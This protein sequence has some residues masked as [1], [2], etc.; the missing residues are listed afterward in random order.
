MGLCNSGGMLIPETITITREVFKTATLDVKNA[1]D[2]SL[3]TFVNLPFRKP[4]E[5]LLVKTVRRMKIV[6]GKLFDS[7][8]VPAE[9]NTKNSKQI[10][11][12]IE[13]IQAALLAPSI[14]PSVQ[15]YERIRDTPV[16]PRTAE[17]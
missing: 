7:I 1:T 12:L 4:E 10:S 11:G 15:K 6:L 9:K 17:A 3:R 13:K 14:V 8:V 5:E 2:D 16:V